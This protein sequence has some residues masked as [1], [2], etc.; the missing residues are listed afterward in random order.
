MASDTFIALAALKNG[1]V[2]GGLAAYELRKFE[3]ER[4]EIYNYDL[5]VA[6]EP[7]REGIATALIQQL[8]QLVAARAAY[9]IF[10]QADVGDESALAPY[11][12]LGVRED[13]L[14]FD[15]R[16]STATTLHKYRLR[17]PPA[18]KSQRSMTEY[19]GRSSKPPHC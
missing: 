11:S 3:K 12:K 5:A 18:A 17:P 15:T 10:V 19:A 2:A 8:K 9:V 13:V 7:R 16:S 6:P 4:S 1:E 14:H